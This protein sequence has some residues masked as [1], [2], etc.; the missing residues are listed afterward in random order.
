MVPQDS[1]LGDKDSELISEHS[2]G[3]DFKKGCVICGE[4]ISKGMHKHLKACKTY[5]KFTKK[6]SEGFKCKLCSTKTSNINLLRAHIKSKHR[7]E[8][9][10]KSTN[11]EGMKTQSDDATEMTNPENYEKGSNLVT[12]KRPKNIVKNEDNIEPSKE[13]VSKTHAIKDITNSNKSGN[14]CISFES[15]DNEVS[16]ENEEE[17]DDDR[18]LK[19]I[20]TCPFDEKKYASLEDIENHIF[21]IH[22]IPKK[23]QRETMHREDAL[24]KIKK[25]TL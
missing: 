2:K 8:I 6:T 15:P 1:Q 23:L 24:L 3:R 20:Y 17:D 21:K 7:K 18:A 12:Q 10:E 4:M 5:Y 19:T 14:S 13:K 16:D 25:E 11:I 22:K 9:L